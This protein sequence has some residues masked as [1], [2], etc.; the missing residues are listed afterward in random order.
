MRVCG[1]PVASVI[2]LTV[3]EATPSDCDSNTTRVRVWRVL[4]DIVS[5]C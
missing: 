5:C 1:T 3:T 4:T 2:S